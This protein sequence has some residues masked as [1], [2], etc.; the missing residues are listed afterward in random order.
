MTYHPSEL[1]LYCHVQS[2]ILDQNNGSLTG[3]IQLCRN[4]DCE[5]MTHDASLVPDK[6]D[7]DSRAI[8]NRT[9]S[10]DNATS[11]L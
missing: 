6:V 11:S 2:A 3:D 5:V 7:S 9:S 4:P 8:I 10:E 1:A